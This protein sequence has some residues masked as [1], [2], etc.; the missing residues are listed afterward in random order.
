MSTVRW[1]ILS[2][3]RH[4]E[5]TM[6]PAFRQARETEVV[7]I[8]SRDVERARAY[9]QQ[10]G[11]PVSY[12]S[13]EALLDDPNIDA[14]YIPLPNNMHK[15]WA[16]K[17]AQAGK[18]VLCEKPI[19]LNATEAEEMVAAFAEAGRVLAETFQWRHHP[20]A[21]AVRELIE[22]GTIGEVRFID[23][24]FSFLI[25]REDDIRLDPALGGGSLYDVGCY[26][27]SLARF[28]VQ[29]EPLAV[30]AQAHWTERG[31]DDR[32]AATLEF[33]NG[34][35]AHINCGFSLPLRRYYEVVGSLG[36]LY[37]NRAYNPIGDRSSEIVR[38]GDDR[39]MIETVQ[40]EP[41]NSYT[42]MVEDFNRAVTGEAPPRFPAEDAVK[43]M[44]VIDALYRS[45]REGGTVEVA[46]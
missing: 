12:G 14:I 30:T 37:V 44:R 4:G 2:T 5:K 29:D 6:L 34:V 19:A 35:L 27:V 8:A 15:E 32:M 45:A 21:H 9:A 24:G 25:A 36:S 28:M 7:A 33:P 10:H 46:R 31:V 41:A 17:A 38:Y 42:L 20:Q 40:L 13:Y 1:G 18:H 3:A 26:P 11:I 43:N 23:A 22:D 39:M 16:I